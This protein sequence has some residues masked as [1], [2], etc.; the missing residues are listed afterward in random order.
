MFDKYRDD[1]TNSPDTIQMTGAMAYFK[2]VDISI[3]DTSLLV[4]SEF[5]GCPSLGDIPRSG[6][7]SAWA[8]LAATS[9]AAQKAQLAGLTKHFTQPEARLQG[10]LYRRVYKHTFKL[11]CPAGSKSVPLETAAE[12]WKM[13]FSAGGLPW[14]SADGKTAWLD[15]YLGFLQERWKKA[16]NKDLWDQTLLFAL[17]TLE[18]ESLSWWS[19]DS[20]W[21]GVIDEFVAWTKKRRD[22]GGDADAMEE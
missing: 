2:D 5:L 10:G 15:L 8:P 16:V 1:P 13:L 9:V 19:E 17:K 20:A 22:G 18:D 6:F 12:F 4:A 14:A 7:T 3:E 21:P 11:A